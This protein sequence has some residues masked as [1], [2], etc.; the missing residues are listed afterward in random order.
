ML[1]TQK[2]GDENTISVKLDAK[3]LLDLAKA[4]GAT[5]DLVTLTFQ[6]NAKGNVKDLPVGQVNTWAPVL[7][8]P[9]KSAATGVIML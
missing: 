2:E 3:L 1:P 8:T 9:N 7:V 5:K 4:L 6:V